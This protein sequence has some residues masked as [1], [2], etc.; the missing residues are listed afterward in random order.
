MACPG[1]CGGSRVVTND[2]QA[3]VPKQ[4]YQSLNQDCPYTYSQLVA[5]LNQLEQVKS[6]D[7]YDIYHIT[8]FKLN[9]DIGYLRSAL[10]FP[11]NLC[12]YEAQLAAILQLINIINNVE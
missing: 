9:S 6:T 8:L 10:N 2:Y 4:E 3:Y 11:K 1:G 5:W 7:T 12:F